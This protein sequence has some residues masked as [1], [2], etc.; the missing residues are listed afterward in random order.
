MQSMPVTFAKLYTSGPFKM[1][2]PILLDHTSLVRRIEGVPEYI[3]FPRPFIYRLSGLPRPLQ[4]KYRWLRPPILSLEDQMDLRAQFLHFNLQLLR[5]NNGVCF[6]MFLEVPLHCCSMRKSNHSKTVSSD[7]DSSD[8]IDDI[9]DI[10]I[11]NC[12]IPQRSSFPA[13]PGC[14]E[15]EPSGQLTVTCVWRHPHLPLGMKEI[16][17]NSSHGRR[18]L[19]RKT[20]SAEQQVEIRNHKPNP[21]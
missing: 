1:M 2:M 11:W 5:V 15:F 7:W 4:G 13:L 6:W 10:S 17:E 16:S 19:P 9:D 8:D 3:S 20:G 12:Q 18:Q 21:L 14:S